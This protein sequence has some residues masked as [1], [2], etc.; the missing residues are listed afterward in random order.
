M[1]IT[2]TIFINSVS[3]QPVILWVASTVYVP[4]AN[5][6]IDGFVPILL[7]GKVL[8]P[9]NQ[10]KVYPTVA[11]ATFEVAEPFGIVHEVCCA[12]VF[13]FTVIPVVLPTI[14]VKGLDTHPVVKLVATT[15]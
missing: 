8:F 12:T 4:A 7:V 13:A 14:T 11:P 6:V 5:P 1:V 10:L 9:L 15:V 2:S 3:E